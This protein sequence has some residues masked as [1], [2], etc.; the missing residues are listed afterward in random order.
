MRNVPLLISCF[1]LFLPILGGCSLFK[2]N[3]SVDLST[4]EKAQTLLLS[5]LE[6]K[7]SQKFEVEGKVVYK[8]YH[9]VTYLSCD[10]K[11]SKGN[12]AGAY[13][14]SKNV[15]ND[16]YYSVPYR[17]KASERILSIFKTE[18]DIEKCTVELEA[19]NLN[20]KISTELSIDDFMVKTGCSYRIEVEIKK[21]NS[22]K[23]YFDKIYSIVSN[24]YDVQPNAFMITISSDGKG[25]YT[26][27]YTRGN[28][29]VTQDSIQE[30][31]DSQN[32]DNKYIH[33]GKD[34][35]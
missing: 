20:E 35:K 14:S 4:K 6:S 26:D 28:R 1:L 5:R 30:G 31:I 13:M 15:F 2:T 34:K 27:S 18:S 24:L 7:Y 21:Q 17:T 19:S 3:K 10:I 22:D 25:I 32:Y 29:K 11:D 12:I 23:A 33:N 9:G 16:N 8:T